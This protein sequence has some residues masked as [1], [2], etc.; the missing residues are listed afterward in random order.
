MPMSRIPTVLSRWLPL[1]L[2]AVL[3][4]PPASEAQAKEDKKEEKA[5][6]LA[7]KKAIKGFGK[8]LAKL[9]RDPRVLK[10]LDEVRKILD[11]LKALANPDA[12]A[13]A[14]QGA[15]IPDTKIRER[16]FQFAEENHDKQLLK[17]LLAILEAKDTRRDAE[18]K[19]LIVHA[20]AVLADEKAI[21]P[22]AGLIRF[23]EDAEV[24]A[25]TC[26]TLAVFSAA[27]IDKRR[28]AVKALV[29]LYS[30]TWTYRM[31]I[32]P[33]DKLLTA[34]ATKR[35]RIYAPQMRGALQS[36][37]GRQWTKPK[38]WRRWWNDCKKARDWKTC[39]SK[40]DKKS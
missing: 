6:E 11:G 36:L 15:T 29:T 39:K 8:R 9:S 14:L 24:V 27:K 20:L 25:E 1:L 28:V 26:T 37:T 7:R 10:K 2:M 35:W 33:E 3:A 40:L 32:R 12:G 21:E 38:E 31:S 17:P 30:T 13:A 18:L 5:A 4:L 16:I 23:D 22:L 19:R 34:R